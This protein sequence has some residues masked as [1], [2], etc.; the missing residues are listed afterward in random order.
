M[1]DLSDFLSSTGGDDPRQQ[2]EMAAQ[3][4]KLMGMPPT[5][6]DVY[7]SLQPVLI[8]MVHNTITHGPTNVVESFAYGRKNYLPYQ[9]LQMESEDEQEEIEDAEDVH[10][11]MDR[12]VAIGTWIAT[13][14]ADALEIDLPWVAHDRVEERLGDLCS[15]ALGGTV[16]GVSGYE[17]EFIDMVSG[18]LDAAVAMSGGGD[19]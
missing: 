16:P 6:V 14:T 2:A 13:Y 19:E 7:L 17:R 8:E 15:V 12:A 1:H 3:F 18:Y 4:R 11:L 5:R 10:A 9:L